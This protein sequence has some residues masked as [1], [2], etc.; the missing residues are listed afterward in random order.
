MAVSGASTAMRCWGGL[1]AASTYCSETGT[2][3]KTATEVWLAASKSC[4]QVMCRKFVTTRLRG[5]QFVT[6]AREDAHGHLSLLADFSIASF[7]CR[8]VNIGDSGP[9]PFKNI[10]ALAS[11]LV[12][13]GIV[14]PEQVLL[15]GA[16]CGCGWSS[17]PI[18]EDHEPSGI[19]EVRC[20]CSISGKVEHLVVQFKSS[21]CMTIFMPDF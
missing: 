9:V 14:S 20:I 8:V 19:P 2:E 4:M 21:W 16:T 11:W 1:S 15:V 5:N 3:D 13:S 17:R 7:D 12:K 6:R 10:C 18:G